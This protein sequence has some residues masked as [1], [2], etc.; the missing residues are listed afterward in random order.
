M[1]V[2]LGILTICLLVSACSR[3]PATPGFQFVEATI[4]DIHSAIERGDA[5][6]VDIIAGYLARI[7][8]YDKSTGLNSIIFTNPN[9]L[10]KAGV[11]DV[12]A[13]RVHEAAG[14]FMTIVAI[15]QRYPG[16]S[17]QAAMVAAPEEVRSG[18]AA[19]VKP[20]PSTPER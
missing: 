13:V 12:T 7:D 14:R 19:A 11:P 8:A 15:K 9:A 1:P 5:R 6:C 3:E 16:H 2:I 18:G 17:R 20:E 10:E 4:A